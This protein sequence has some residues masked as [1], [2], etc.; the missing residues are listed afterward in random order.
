MG[1][2]ARVRVTVV[3]IGAG[4]WA[5]AEP[6]GRGAV[7][8]ADVLLGG[9]RHL[10]MV[11][12]GAAPAAI[13]EPWPSPLLDGLDA[14]L[15]RHDG[16][17][18]VALASGDPLV[19]GIGSTLVRRLGPKALRVIPAVSSAALARARMGW[20]ADDCDVVTLVGRDTDRL[21]RYLAPG[22]RL[23]VLTGG[24]E[25]PATVARLLAGEG[26]GAS[27]MTLLAELGGQAESRRDGAADGMLGVE[28]A[29]LG[30]VCVECRG[31]PGRS[32]VP[33]LPDD[34]FENDGQ[35]SRRP[36][37]AAAVSALAPRPGELLWDVG[38]GAGSVGI[39]WARGAPGC[40]VL[41]IERDAGRAETV[42]RN[43]ARLGVPDLVTVVEGAAPDALG[44]LER[45]DAVF[46]GGGGSR[47]G[48][49]DKCWS[50]LPAGGR[51]VAHAVTL[52]TQAVLAEWHRV[53]GGELLRYAVDAAGPIGSF[54]GWEPMRPVVQWCGVKT[55][56]SESKQETSE[57]A[58][59]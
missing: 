43:A 47:P 12:D 50:A 36:I 39:E 49:L 1:P 25:G 8:D 26:F 58:P 29:A 55:T 10:A 14:L 30:L 42:R 34:A 20:P 31:G 54:T 4:G 44:G 3:G 56:A 13:R 45:P 59:E 15:E 7:H 2:E 16:R 35:L 6:A 21:R 48:V 27:S 38:A 11:P 57:G 51:L 19:S 46:V 18:V 22:R 32:R 28:G 41:A 17:N 5:T 9:Q 40:R 37:R 33:G 53:H 52:E 23:I 24:V